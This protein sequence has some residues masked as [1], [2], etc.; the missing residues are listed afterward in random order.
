MPDLPTGV[1]WTTDPANAESVAPS[2]RKSEFLCSLCLRHIHGHEAMDPFSRMKPERRPEVGQVERSG[3]RHGRKRIGQAK[4][5]SQIPQQEEPH[6]VL[7]ARHAGLV[8]LRRQKTL[9][10]YHYRMIYEI[11]KV[12]TTTALVVLVSG[13]SRRSTLAGGVL[14]SVPLVSVLADSYVTCSGRE[15][16]VV[17]S[18][19]HGGVT[20]YR[21]SPLSAVSS[22]AIWWR[23]SPSLLAI[24]EPS[25]RRAFV[26]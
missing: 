7:R 18:V 10:R 24:P 20:R 19:C 14:A 23:R 6:V 5:Q 2:D 3:C 25:V 13:V 26:F 1:A 16:A 17:R 9:S 8:P 22:S 21:S 11:V 12:L 4:V 15:G